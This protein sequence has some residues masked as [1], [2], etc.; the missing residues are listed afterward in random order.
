M[1]FGGRLQSQS[2]NLTAK[3]RDFLKRMRSAA[4]RMSTLI[5]DLLEFSRINIRGK[6]FQKV[7]LD[8]VVKDCIDDLSVLI[9]ETGVQ[10][11]I[12]KLP[13]II[14]DPLQMQQLL[15]NLIANAIKFSQ[16]D[17]SPQVV[18]SVTSVKAPEAI[19]LERLGDWICL[20]IK[21]NGIGFDQENAE[22]IFAPFQ[23]LHSRKD[24]KGTGI[25]LAI[26]RRIVE[27]HNGVIEAQSGVDQGAVFKVTLPMDNYLIDVKQTTSAA[28]V[29]ASNGISE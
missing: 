19:E 21:D 29:N 2:E 1:A 11:H 16:T 15:F 10:L 13:Q 23:R 27:R 22:K 28:H 8:A 25:G 20:T 4:S 14:A 5:N 24:F 18:V 6:S 26:C 9:E 3:Q 17:P 12:Q 7:D